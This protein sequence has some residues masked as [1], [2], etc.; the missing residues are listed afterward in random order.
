MTHILRLIQDH[1]LLDTAAATLAILAEGVASQP[2]MAFDELQRFRHTLAQHLNEEA[3]VI[4][5]S[6]EHGVTPFAEHAAAHRDAFADL[7]AEWET[8]LREWSEDN[9][10][11][12]WT[13][14]GD[15]TR[16]MMGRLR[17]QIRAENDILY[18][19]AVKHGLVSMRVAA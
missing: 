4:A 11:E 9:I 17:E 7:V 1:T 3:K 10:R 13:G 14:F 2:E 15:A 19:L 6:H 18:P 16:W 5:A 8:Y 12:D